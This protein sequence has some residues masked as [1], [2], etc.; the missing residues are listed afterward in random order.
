V[1]SAVLFDVDFTLIYPGPTFRGEGYQRFGVRHGLELDAARFEAGVALAA[2]VL[3]EAQGD[4][5]DPAIFHRYTALIIEAMGGAGPGV[6]ACA[7]QIYD[8]WAS[9]H[10][11]HLYEDVPEVLRSL[12]G[13]GLRLGLISNSH[14]CLASF[15]SHFELEGLVSAAVSSSVHGYLKPHPSIFQ[16]ALGLLGVAPDEAVMVGDSLGQDIAGARGVG[17]R[18]VLVRRGADGPSGTPASP[19]FP[20]VPVIHSLRALPPLL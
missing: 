8:E 1:T 17:M 15:Q 6:D 11:F 5:Y 20:D 7:V 19:D 18:A 16:S 12:A 10:H 14:R 2:P 3:D 9:N 13:R 4:I